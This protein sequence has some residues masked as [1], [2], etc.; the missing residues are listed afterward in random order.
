MADENIFLKTENTADESSNNSNNGQNGSSVDS[1]QI[2]TDTVEMAIESD[3]NL[4]G[5]LVSNF[6][7]EDSLPIGTD[8]MKK[9]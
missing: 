7:A 2:P 3:K 5:D 8:E 1:L 4:D 6:S 9:W